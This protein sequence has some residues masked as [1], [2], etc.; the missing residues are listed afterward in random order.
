MWNTAYD[1]KLWINCYN[2]TFDLTNL[3]FSS[4]KHLNRSSY[5]LHIPKSA[6]PLGHHRRP[7]S[8]LPPSL[9]VLSSASLKASPSFRPVHS[10]ILSSHLFLFL[11]LA[12]CPCTVPCKIV[13]AR[14]FDPYYMSIPLQ[15]AFFHLKFWTD[16]FS[17]QSVGY[18]FVSYF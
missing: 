14:P 6:R 3:P 16:A 9:P 13:L 11:P 12:L 15:V 18:I 8:K 5:I 17:K 4:K 7:H 10:W 2:V 1:G